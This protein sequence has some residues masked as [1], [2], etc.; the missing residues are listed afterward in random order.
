[1]KGYRPDGSDFNF[2]SNGFKCAVGVY[3]SDEL[4]DDIF[5]LAM[6][7]QKV[8]G[9]GEAEFQDWELVHVMDYINPS[10]YSDSSECMNVF[11]AAANP[12]LKVATGGNIPEVPQSFLDQLY[13][14]CRY[15]LKFD[16]VSGVTL[17]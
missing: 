3:R 15:G 13:W 8:A 9:G 17:K 4:N 14:L 7:K 5:G 1:M 11:L 10:D 16:Q 2:V 6:V 12:K